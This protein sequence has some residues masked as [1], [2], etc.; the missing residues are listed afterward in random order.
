[1]SWQELMGGKQDGK[2]MERQEETMAV[3]VRIKEK[4]KQDR[5]EQQSIART[6]TLSGGIHIGGGASSDPDEKVEFKYRGDGVDREKK[7]GEW[8]SEGQEVVMIISIGRTV[9]IQ[10]MEAER[11]GVRVM[12]E[13]GKMAREI[14][15]LEGVE[16]NYGLWCPR[17]E[18]PVEWQLVMTIGLPTMPLPR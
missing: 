2:E 4:G 7:I 16:S 5:V 10:G 13:R 12:W 8:Y 1:M 3:T 11:E 9:V 6:D 15:A 14:P 17:L 18:Q